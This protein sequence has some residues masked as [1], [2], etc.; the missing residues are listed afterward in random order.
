MTLSELQNETDGHLQSLNLEVIRNQVRTEEESGIVP[1]G[2]AHASR[3]DT[4]DGSNYSVL[5]HFHRNKPPKEVR[6]N[7]KGRNGM[8]KETKR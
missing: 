1:C 4:P 6:K 3:H 2:I 8:K 5:L 7:K